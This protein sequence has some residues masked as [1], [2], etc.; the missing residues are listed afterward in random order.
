MSDTTGMSDQEMFRQMSAALFERGLKGV[1]VSFHERSS[2]YPSDKFAV[3]ESELHARRFAMAHH[4][5]DMR[6]AFLPVDVEL[7]DHL[8]EQAVST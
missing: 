3:H 7:A 8:D 2:G 6:V 5:P 1:W 4:D